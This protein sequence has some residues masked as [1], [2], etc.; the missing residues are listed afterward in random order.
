MPEDGS[1]LIDYAT[2]FYTVMTVSVIAI[3]W[4]EALLPQ[5]PGGLNLQHMLRNLVLWLIAFFTADILVGYYWIDIQSLITQQ[6]FGVFYWIKLPGDWI[7]VIVGVLVIDA[8]DYLYHRLSHRV[9]FLWRFHSVHHTD[10]SLDVSTTLR[11]HPVD[12]VFSNFAKIGVGLFFGIPLWV[13]GFRELLLFPFLFLQHANVSLPPRVEALL[14]TIVVMPRIHRIHHSTIR[15]EHDS[16]YGVG[17]VFW[18]KLLGSF[19]APVTPRPKVY[20]LEHRRGEDYQSIDGML[21]TPLKM[22]RP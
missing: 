10:L 11:A 9:H 6:P 1:N 22:N 13:I 20:G 2:S 12:L 21:L 18:D 15:S 7:L 8:G 4:L 17:L 5:E 3:L 16:N 19:T 14:S